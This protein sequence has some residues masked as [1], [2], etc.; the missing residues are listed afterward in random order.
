MMRWIAIVA[1]AFTV[2]SASASSL[3]E[4]QAF[5]RAVAILRGDPYGNSY[6]EVASVIKSATLITKG[7]SNCGGTVK[8][9]V[10][11]LHVVVP[12]TNRNDAIDG[13]L[14]IDASTGKMVCA[15]LPFLD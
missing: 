10:W 2:S 9:P 1:L 4:A 15:S 8:R 11:S 6:T 3:N 13:T 7:S 12:K 5:T 14:D